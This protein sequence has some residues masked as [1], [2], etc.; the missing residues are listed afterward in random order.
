MHAKTNSG[1][2]STAP[3]EKPVLPVDFLDGEV[4]SGA[5]TPNY[6]GRF[7]SLLTISFHY[8]AG[9][10]LSLLIISFHYYA[11]G[12]LSFFTISFHL[13]WR[14]FLKTYSSW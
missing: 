8:Y 2:R 7:L 5:G 3:S 11:G 1:D 4:E 14:Y 10:F 13:S 9:G 12:F 6:S